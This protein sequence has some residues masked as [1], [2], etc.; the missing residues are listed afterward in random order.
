MGTSSV[1]K[2][3]ERLHAMGCAT[4]VCSGRL[5]GA[6]TAKTECRKYG[7]TSLYVFSDKIDYTQ[8]KASTPCVSFG[9]ILLPS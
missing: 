5:N 3:G 6:E 7:E 8:T 2:T 9:G 1:Q 4:T